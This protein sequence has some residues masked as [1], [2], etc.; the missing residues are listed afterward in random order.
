[1]NQKLHHM[2]LGGRPGGSK[3]NMGENRFNAIVRIHTGF[4]P[5]DYNCLLAYSSGTCFHLLG[6]KSPP[7]DNVT[8]VACNHNMTLDPEAWQVGPDT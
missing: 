8:H 6:V 1:M 4:W 3:E 5:H 2:A 7:A